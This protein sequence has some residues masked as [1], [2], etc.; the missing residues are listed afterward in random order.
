MSEARA[1]R[2][3][4]LNERDQPVELHCADGVVVLPPRG[5]AELDRRD[6]ESPH[7]QVLAHRRLISVRPT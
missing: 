4:V 2:V 1:A 5:E 7:V 3:R 6:V